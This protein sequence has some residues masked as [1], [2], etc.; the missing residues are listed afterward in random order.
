MKLATF[1]MA[2]LTLMTLTA[3]RESDE[4]LQADACTE[5]N[6]LQASLAALAALGPTS[7][8]DQ[9]KDATKEVHE[10]AQDAARAVR[11]VEDERAEELRDAEENL[12]DAVDDVDD[13][14]AVVGALAQIQPQIA[15]VESARDQM[16]AS[17]NCQ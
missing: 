6:N 15:A 5:L 17:L 9:Y 10:S 11:R 3:C 14:Q 7:T 1:L 12:E 16:T 4:D 2:V 13:D 8:V